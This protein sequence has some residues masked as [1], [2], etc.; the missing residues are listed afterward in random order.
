[1][2]Q[3]LDIVL[4]SQILLAGSLSDGDLLDVMGSWAMCWQG[5]NGV[6][7]EKRGEIVSA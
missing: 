5:S 4:G 2:A 3:A 6:F 1:V 7:V